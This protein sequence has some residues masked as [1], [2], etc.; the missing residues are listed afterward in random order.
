MEKAAHF[1]SRS[2]VA[3]IDQMKWVAAPKLTGNTLRF[4]VISGALN[5]CIREKQI[6]KILKSRAN[7]KSYDDTLKKYNAINSLR[8]NPKK[9]CYSSKRRF[10][11]LDL[12]KLMSPAIQA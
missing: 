8:K 7:A 12:T 11:K 10:E 2:L 4:I 9:C 3:F 1:I 5:L 6:K